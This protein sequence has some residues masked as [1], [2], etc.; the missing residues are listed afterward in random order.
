MSVVYDKL[1]KISIPGQ[2]LTLK[3]NNIAFNSIKSDLPLN[4][5]GALKLLRSDSDVYIWSLTTIS[6]F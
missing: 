3:S 4:H 5:N 2:P 6:L 1:C